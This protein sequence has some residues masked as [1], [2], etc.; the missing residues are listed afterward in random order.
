MTTFSYTAIPI[1][2]AAARLVSGRREA[3]DE[4]ALRD[5]LRAQ[6]LIA[7]D[8]RPVSPIDA[9][10]AALSSDRPRRSDS[11]WLFQ[12][13]RAMLS[14]KVPIESAITT[15]QELAPSPRLARV[16]A[17]IRE[18]LRGGATLADAIAK[19]PGLASPQHLALLR[20]GEQSGR[21]DHVV[22]LID[23]SISSSEK[24]RRTLTS[25]LI[26]P[27]IL[28]VA[29]I[30]AVWFLATFVIP[31]FAGTLEALGGS[32]PTPTRITLVVA[33][34]GVWVIPPLLVGAVAAWMFR[35][36]ILTP[37]IRRRIDELV[38]RLPV[39][40]TL[41]WSRQAGVITDVIATMIEGGGDVLAAMDQAH[42]VVSSP[43]IAQRL[44]I[45][46]QAVREGAD[47]GEALHDQGVLPPLLSA[48]VRAGSRS[49]DLAPALRR[50]SDAAVQTQDVLSSRLMVLLEPAVILFLAATVGW[51]VY[52]L[53][54]G[55]LA[56][57][58]AAAG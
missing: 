25:R 56:M 24:T 35:A 52:S 15:M 44:A 13:L 5:D 48:M 41:S 19:K 32:I 49:G 51:V 3:P 53:I 54:V 39:L 27:L 4:R 1:A 57:N 10:R 17:D 29:A 46:R 16:C 58:E 31:R 38:L 33:K 20:T 40:G 11:V 45:A 14:G 6:G 8:V 18:S 9:L 12:T 50:A 37:Q 47:L 2:R 30:L 34:A 23:H 42:E 7:I 22:T 28:L 43:V 21:L 55:M 26:Y 36:A